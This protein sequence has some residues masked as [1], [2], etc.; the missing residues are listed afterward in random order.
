MACV[1]VARNQ[2]LVSAGEPADYVYFVFEG[3]MRVYKLV[4]DGR[5]QISGFL[6]PEDF[7]GLAVNGRYGYSADA[8]IPTVVCRMPWAKFEQFIDD[9]P[10]L[11]RH[12]LEEVGNKLIS[13]QDRL[14][15]LGRRS[16]SK[17]LAWFLLMLA[18]RQGRDRPATVIHLVMGRADIADYLG[19]TVETVSRSFTSLRISDL[20]DAPNSHTV[21]LLDPN[22]LRDFADS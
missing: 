20:I 15:V 16:S 22:R 21:R 12:L 18:Q 4:S 13:A 6:Y 11:E 14:L 3:M 9:V 19:L 5:R 10:R 2:V 1:P 7:L 17:R 8:V